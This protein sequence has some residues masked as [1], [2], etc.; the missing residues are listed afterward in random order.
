MFVSSASTKPV[1]Q[2]SFCL[3]KIQRARFVRQLGKH[4]LEK[5]MRPAPVFYGLAMAGL[6]VVLGAPAS[7][8]ALPAG[9]QLD[10]SRRHARRDLNHVDV[11]SVLSGGY[12]VE[13]SGP[14]VTS[15]PVDIP[16]PGAPYLSLGFYSTWISEIQ[17]E[18][19]GY[20]AG[21]L[22]VRPPGLPIRRGSG[23]TCRLQSRLPH[24]LVVKP[25]TPDFV[26][27]PGYIV[28]NVGKHA[29]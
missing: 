29:V 10:E 6:A 7:S 20:L 21:C 27:S 26:S 14:A 28:D 12:S 18:D 4:V 11:C 1:A 15:V 2:K 19:I 17:P 8:T 13:C 9:A 5:Q 3:T 16:C 25:H 24:D 23:G 22:Y